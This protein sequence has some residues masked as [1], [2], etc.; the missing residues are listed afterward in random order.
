MDPNL[1]QKELQAKLKKRPMS[2][3][4]EPQLKATSFG[5]LAAPSEDARPKSLS[6]STSNIRQAQV[7]QN[8]QISFACDIGKKDVASKSMQQLPQKSEPKSFADEL[9]SKILKKRPSSE[10]IQKLSFI[11]DE[12]KQPETKSFSDELSSQITKKRPPIP[13]ESIQKLSPIADESEQSDAT[14]KR[15]ISS[16]GTLPRIVSTKR[17]GSTRYRNT[18]WTS[19][20]NNPTAPVKPSNHDDSVMQSTDYQRS[21]SATSSSEGKYRILNLYLHGVEP[22]EYSQRTERERLLDVERHF[23]SMKSMYLSVGYDVVW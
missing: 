6:V 12:N 15:P 14:K 19:S 23:E 9:S 3:F 11:D 20:P 22:G 5:H 17:R 16:E 7:E 4:V 21:N 10:S 8:K 1:F 13:P 2:T 18:G